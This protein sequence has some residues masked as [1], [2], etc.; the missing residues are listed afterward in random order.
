MK[1]AL[2]LM[3]NYS[4]AQMALWTRCLDHHEALFLLAPV[5][6][7]GEVQEGSNLL[8]ALRMHDDD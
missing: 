6:Y 5:H 1:L 8:N 3:L 7:P 2:E 4:M